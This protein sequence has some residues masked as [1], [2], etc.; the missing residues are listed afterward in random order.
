MK[1]SKT[2]ENNN[3]NLF[4]AKQFWKKQIQIFMLVAY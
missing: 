4:I 1:T 2:K 3:S